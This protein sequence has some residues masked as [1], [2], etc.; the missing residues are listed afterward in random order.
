MKFSIHKQR[1]ALKIEIALYLLSQV[2]Q[3]IDNKKTV[4]V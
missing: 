4:E 3:V 1:Q 2:K